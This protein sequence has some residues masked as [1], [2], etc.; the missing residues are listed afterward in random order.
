MLVVFGATGFLGRHVIS[1]AEGHGW[2]VRAIGRGLRPELA[3][4]AVEWVGA[5]FASP[6]TVAAA[7]REGDTVLNLAF[8]RSEQENHEL[9]DAL[10]Q[11]CDKKRAACFVHCSTAVVAGAFRGPTV[12]E[13][14][15][16]SPQDTYERLKM[17]LEQRVQRAA[18]GGLRTIIVRPT[19]IVGPQGANL[20]SLA[21]SLLTGSAVWNYFRACAFGDRPM[22]LVPVATVASA[23]LYLAA[24]PDRF[25]GETFIIAADDDPDNRFPVVERLLAA[26]LNLPRRSLPVLPLPRMLLSTVLRLRGRSDPAGE[27]LYSSE[28]LRA[29]GFVPAVA[30]ADAVAGFG[31]WYRRSM[32]PVQGDAIP[33]Q[34]GP[35]L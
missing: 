31:E 17:A 2:P 16:C 26:A 19:A 24:A 8:A 29:T 21:R 27:R 10:L 22:H 11:A 3:S 32:V 9:L 4:G 13:D 20:A 14:T 30:V 18:R 15:P 33:R 12:T 35:G 6:D 5:D 1:A 23:I 7:I 25:G 34:A 28:K